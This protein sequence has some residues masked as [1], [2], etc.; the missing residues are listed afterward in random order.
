MLK[1]IAAGLAA[2]SAFTAQASIVQRRYVGEV[3]PYPLTPRQ[4]NSTIPSNSTV[5]S[6]STIPS[7]STDS[8][9]TYRW[10]QGA[11]K[12]W[13]DNQAAET[14][15]TGTMGSFMKDNKITQMQIS[16]GKNGEQLANYAFN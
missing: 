2:Q 13:P 4:D 16:V 1:L 12:S 10:H 14:F 9:W 3:P 5:P 11:L 8:S 15:F 6:N 7:N